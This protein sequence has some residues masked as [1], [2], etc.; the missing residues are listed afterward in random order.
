MIYH[1]IADARY[2]CEHDVFLMNSSTT[3]VGFLFTVLLS[4]GH[5]MEAHLSPDPVRKDITKLKKYIEDHKVT[6]SFAPPQLAQFLIDDNSPL[7][8][9]I[10]G[11]DKA[12]PFD[13]KHVQV[14]NLYGLTE[15]NGPATHYFCTN[16]VE[17]DTPIGTPMDSVKLYLLDDELKPVK[18]GEQGQI[19][20]AGPKLA[21]GYLNNP[22]ITNEKFIKNPFATNEQDK[23]LFLS[24]DIGREF[25]DGN[26]I[27]V[28]RNDWMVN[29]NG[30]RVEPGEVENQI[31][32]IPAI[33][34]AVVKGFI[35]QDKQNYLCA[36]YTVQSSITG[37][38]IKEKLAKFL[39]DYMMPSFFV[40][41]AEIPLNA[42]GKV[43]RKSLPA[44]ELSKTIREPYQAARNEKEETICKAF[45]Q[46]LG[47]EGVGIN[48]NFFMLGG[49]SIKAMKLQ[50]LC[51]KLGVTMTQ[52]MQEKTPA[53]I[54]KVVAD[55]NDTEEIIKIFEKKEYY[56][57]T[58]NQL[59]LYYEWEKDNEVLQYNLPQIIKLSNKVD[60]N[61]LK[62]AALK[63]M[64]AHPYLKTC[65]GRKEGQVVQ[66]RKDEEPITIEISEA[67][68]ADI[69]NLKKAF[70][71]SFDLFQGPL[72]RIAIYYTEQHTYLFM[73]IHHIIV[74]GSTLGIFNADLA[75]AYNGEELEKENYTAF[76]HALEE[77]EMVGK[78][79]YQK[80]ET[81]FDNKLKVT[82][83][84]LPKMAKG[85][86]KGQA[87]F[88]VIPV[89]GDGIRKFCQDNAV[90]PSNLF[91][92]AFCY[93]LYR[94]TGEE[95]IAIT[96]ISHG[97]NENKLMNIMGM[98]VKT[99]PLV[100]T[101]ENRQNTLEL[102]QSVQENMIETIENEI[103]PLT[104][105][106]EKHKFVPQINYVYQGGM[107]EPFILEDQWVEVEVLEVD[108]VK[109]PLA[110]SIMPK[111]DSYE[112]SI[113]Y[114]ESLYTK[115]YIQ[116]LS[117]AI[118]ECA[119]QIAEKPKT[120]CQN[121]SIVNQEQIKLL[122][123]FNPVKD[124][125]EDKTLQELFEETAKA[126]GDHTALIAMD[127]TLSYAELNAA[128]N[129]IANALIAKGI[130]PEDK[131][132][133]LLP[134]DSRLI[135]T[136]FGI[137]KSGGAFIPVD[138]E[139]PEE[140]IKHVLEDSDAKFI[141]TTKEK[142]GELNFSNGLVVDELLQKEEEYNPRTEVKA[143]NLCY[144]IYTSGSTG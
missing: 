1:D 6:I 57:L 134:R 109:L 88:V 43:D 135:C 98:F 129:K 16:V 137:I 10:I 19:C 93:T 102:I 15:V 9:L 128:A 11:S 39:P 12:V 17:E 116:T 58:E 132:A 86:R 79:K 144:I 53:K 111:T 99:L 70:V 55:N 101:I 133:F 114:D 25:A 138:P 74:D 72:Y 118:A 44:P 69:Q 41:L 78:E 29:I 126:K 80:A 121:I 63:V 31:K 5:G 67:R 40:E 49:D 35:D 14:I 119:K 141:I 112:I 59:G 77:E 56:P 96:T 122:E 87:E 95:N 47:M 130:K 30:F 13:P 90:T 131:V 85:G 61:K 124:E 37:E 71:K 62:V 21:R 54:A 48:D 97:R 142:Q 83:T 28:N 143:N 120:L 81:F 50:L 139:Y 2:G 45:E 127:K 110:I 4:L 34:N 46:I 26:I 84:E 108:K 136:I 105:M 23:I 123:T 107:A 76:E 51:S 106:A 36:F 24:G 22:E 140:R 91:L 33:K 115:E 75:K 64:E 42:N 18:K 65:L 89:Q 100:V 117:A 113:E 92:S 7:K 3:F 32:K 20:F 38:E 60:P 82:M 27:Y 52:I 104:K 73:D 68:E 94:Y 8:K 66:L 103:Y 125:Q